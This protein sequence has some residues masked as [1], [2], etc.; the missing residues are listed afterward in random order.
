MSFCLSMFFL[1][2]SIASV[3]NA[4][5][6]KGIVCGSSTWKIRTHVLKGTVNTS[7]KHIRAN[8]RSV[9]KFCR[10]SFL[11][12]FVIQYGTIRTRVSFSTRINDTD[13]HYKKTLLVHFI[14]GR[15]ICPRP[16]SFDNDP[17]LV[18]T[19]TLLCVYAAP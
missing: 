4:F 6:R 9:R 13:T 14:K 7:S 8:H 19:T 2:A 16:V 1:S 18:V 15:L 11:N 5:S 12:I 3:K 10:S 17:F